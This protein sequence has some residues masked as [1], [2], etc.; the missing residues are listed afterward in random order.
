MNTSFLLLLAIAGTTNTAPPPQT[1]FLFLGTYHMHNPP[2]DMATAKIKDTLSPERQ[3]EIAELN[4]SLAR[5][6]P[7]KIM[8]ESDPVEDHARASYAEYLKGSH[9]LSRDEE[10]QVGFRLAKQ[11]GLPTIYPVD[12]HLR[13][14]VSKI[15]RA[16][17]EQGKTAFIDHMQSV[18]SRST[19]V[20]AELDQKYT[21]GQILAVLNSPDAMR[22]NH[23]EFLSMI[24]VD[25]DRDFIATDTVTKWYQRNLRIFSNIKR[26]V[27]PGD[28]VLVIFGSG[29]MKFLK[30][31]CSETPGFEIED[32]LKYLPKAPKVDWGLKD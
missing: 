17:K 15:F 28:R 4:Q 31:F 6:R 12:D 7:T 22:L 2:G 29:H 26:N 9:E 1:R 19:K 30:E 8:I 27:A 18:I 13:I 14:D 20:L 24:D 3:K 5:F 11:F 21:V 25:S 16:A 10:E 32:T 23:M